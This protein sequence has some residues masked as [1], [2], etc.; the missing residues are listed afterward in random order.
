[1]MHR[2]SIS[3]FLGV[4]LT[5]SLAAKEPIFVVYKIDGPAHDPAR[6]T[7]W[8]GP[9][10]EGSAVFDVNGDGVLDI[11]CGPNWYEGPDWKK[12]E[13]F[14]PSASVKGEYINNCGEYAVDVSG[15]G[16]L[17]LVSAGW[18]EN[19]VFWYENPG[20]E[21][22]SEVW[23]ATKILSSDWTEAL[24]LDDIDGD[25]DPDVLVNHWAKKEGQAVTWL[26]LAG[27]GEFKVHELGTDGDVHGAGVGDLNGDGRKDI[28]TP[29]GWYE[30]PADKSAKWPFH[31]DFRVE[32]TS[33]GMPVIDVNGDGLQDI[34]YGQAHG[35]GLGWLEQTAGDGGGKR[36]FRRHAIEESG[37]VSQ[38][39]T[40]V[41]ADV[42]QDGKLDLVTGKR[43]RGHNGGDASAFDPMGVFW[44]DIRGGEFKRNVLVYNHTFWYPGK[45]SKNQPPQV[46][47]GAGM[48]INAVDIDKN[49]L[50]DI[51]LSGKSGLYLLYNRG[52]PPT[53]KMN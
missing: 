51:V 3:C 16:R 26:E 12:H 42:N 47:V 20:P 17:D 35:Y 49:G 7:Y 8:Y 22:A 10:S 1:M 38:A 2:A 46:A 23:K 28:I 14:R 45:E 27:K 25:G 43:L 39:H 31:P 9:F 13:G 50:V 34:I 29:H 5:T 40:L 4:L 52:L 32:H 18:M 21:K 19:G 33:I 15:D 24:L 37:I 41:L 48:N 11:T 44:Y 36:A 53:P 30:Q 6:Q